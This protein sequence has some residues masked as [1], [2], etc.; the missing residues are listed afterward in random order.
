MKSSRNSLKI[1]ITAVTLLA[2]AA[3]VAVVRPVPPVSANPIPRW[4][5]V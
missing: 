5:K 2:V 1:I 4:R 3:P